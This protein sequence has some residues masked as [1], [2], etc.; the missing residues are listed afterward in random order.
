MELAEGLDIAVPLDAGAALKALANGTAGPE[1][2]KLAWR[3]IVYGL[4]GFDTLY[5]QPKP[6]ADNTTN[7]MLWRE[8]RRFVGGFMKKIAEEPVETAT[9]P[10]PPPRTMTEK[11]R[12]RARNSTTN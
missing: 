5:Y 3:F 9:S 8:G 4:S 6:G 10:L 7:L 12:R 1:E 11:A 2:Q